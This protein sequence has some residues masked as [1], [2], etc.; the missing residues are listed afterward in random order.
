MHAEFRD[1]SC[2]R[3][4]YLPAEAN[5]NELCERGFRALHHGP[6]LLVAVVL[7]AMLDG[8]R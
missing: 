7:L 4:G 2:R 8:E 5:V 1:P 6:L 3:A